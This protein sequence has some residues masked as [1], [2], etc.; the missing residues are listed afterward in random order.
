MTGHLKSNHLLQGKRSREMK[1]VKEFVTKK[2][3]TDKKYHAIIRTET[4]AHHLDHFS[5]MFKELQ[6]DFPGIKEEDTQVCHY[7]GKSYKGTYGLEI[8]TDTIPKG[9]V[10]ISSVEFTL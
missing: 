4:Y 6:S 5:K 7:G 3:P 8:D 10:E 1:F 9:Y 2:H